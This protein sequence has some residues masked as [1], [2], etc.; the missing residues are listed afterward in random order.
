[1]VNPL[2]IYWSFRLVDALWAYRTVYKTP[3]DL[4]PYRIVYGKVY[5]LPTKIEHKMYWALKMINLD[6]NS[7]GPL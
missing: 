3:L 4:S 1:M 2:T 7:A 5:H 6:L